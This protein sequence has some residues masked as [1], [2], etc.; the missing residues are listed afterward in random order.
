M[1]PIGAF[2]EFCNDWLGPVIIVGAVLGV[3][4]GVWAGIEDGNARERA[5]AIGRKAQQAWFADCTKP[6]DECALAW[7]KSYT[8]RG[9]YFER[10]LAE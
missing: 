1:I 7:D 5:E 10:A 4:G 8:L 9:V 6:F 2:N 3:A